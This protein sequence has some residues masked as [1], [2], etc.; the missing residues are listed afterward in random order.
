MQI[1]GTLCEPCGRPIAGD[2]E[3]RACTHCER[4]FHSDC[5]ER[6]C[7]RCG[8]R[9]VGARKLAARRAAEDDARV[10]S[11]VLRGRRLFHAAA[12]SYLLTSVWLAANVY[13]STGDEGRLL[14]AV[15]RLSIA[16]SGMWWISRGSVN[17]AKVAIGLAALGGVVGLAYAT[18]APTWDGALIL[19][20]MGAWFLGIAIR[21]ATSSAFWTYVR[22]QRSAPGMPTSG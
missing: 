17:A 13:A 9:L 6:S 20:L 11:E 5:V 12:A 1:A 18:A 14:T 8:A 3:A 15:V 16:I 2:R 21:L 19:A 4:G 10:R 22:A 7:P